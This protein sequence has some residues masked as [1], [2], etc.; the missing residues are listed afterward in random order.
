MSY[1]RR[2]FLKSGG[3][4][5]AGIGLLPQ[6]L[7]RAAQQVDA[8]RRR[9]VMI[10]IFQRGAAD[11]LNVVVPHGEPSYYT[12]RPS[13]AIPRPSGTQA[14]ALDLDGFFGLHPAM[15][16]LQELY[17]KNH[18]AI[19]HAVGSPDNTR[20]HFD[21]QDFME[22]ATPGVKSTR[23]GWL[24][25]HL[26]VSSPSA[27]MSP[28][29]AVAMGANLP[30]SLAGAAPAVA[31]TTFNDFDVKAGRGADLAKERLGS[32]YGAPN[33]LLSKTG[34]ETLEAVA[35]LKKSNPQQYQPASG[36]VY[37]R[38]P[39]GEGLKQVAQLIKAGVGLEVACAEIGGWDHHANEGSINGQLAQRLRE[40]SEGIAAL[41]TDLGERMEDVVIVTMSE[42]GRTAHENG[43]QGTD[44]GHAN[45]MFVLGGSLRGGKV[46]GRWPGLEKEQLYEGR[47]LAMT[48]DFRDVFAEVL[49]GHMHCADLNRVFPGY[50]VAADRYLRFLA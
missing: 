15:K 24:N 23:D 30:R 26:Q 4:A 3:V 45:A 35:F 47:D 10:A 43:N 27:D 31:M 22:S 18:L 12:M 28:F 5:L 50:T 11:G 14:G 6:F 20:S 46:Y 40:F 32:M 17:A 16:P 37:P 21:A 38:S 7:V 48:T 44:H 2:F 8:S 29:R 41:Y 39:F 42:F 9:K 49:S 36:A 33:D 34:R 25:R 13:I 19:V 1:T